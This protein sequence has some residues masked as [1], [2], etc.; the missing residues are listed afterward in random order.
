MSGSDARPLI[1]SRLVSVRPFLEPA[2]DPDELFTWADIETRH[3]DGS[4]QVW[5]GDDCAMLTEAEGETLHIWLGGGSLKGLLRLRPWAEDQARSWGFER[6]TIDGRP[7]W[8]RLLERHG[9]A[10]RDGLLEKML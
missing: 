7:G 4:V 1:L 10:M 2:L 3:D 8:V 5:V 6:V 9:Y